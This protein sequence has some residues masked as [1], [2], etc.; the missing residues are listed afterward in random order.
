[1][2]S[3]VPSMTDRNSAWLSRNA[4][5]ACLRSVTSSWTQ[6]QCLSPEISS[7]VIRAKVV[8]LRPSFLR[9]LNSPDHTPRVFN[10]SMISPTIRAFSSDE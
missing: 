5:S 3:V 1:M 8:N 10:C 7:A 9:L 6:T 2:G 4:S